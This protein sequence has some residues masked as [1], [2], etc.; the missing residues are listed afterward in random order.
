[1]PEFAHSELVPASADA[2]FRRYFRVDSGRRTR[3]AMDA[4]PP[5]EDCKPFVQIAG[6]LNEMGLQVPEVFEVDIERGFLL[7]SDLGEQRY[8]DAFSEQSEAADTLYRDA[9]TALRTLQRAGEKHLPA[10]PDFDA[11]LLRFEMSLFHDWLCERHLGLVFSSADENCWAECCDALV[12][13]AL[14][15]PTVFVH[16][17]YH[18]RNLM[19]TPENNPGI[20]DFQDAVSGPLTYDLVSLLRDCYIRWPDEK[21][22]DW[23][24]EFYAALDEDLRD[25]MDDATFLQIFDLTGVHRHLKAAGI[26]AR[27]MLRDGKVSYLNHVPRTLQYIVD[28]G[29]RC[30]EIE[31]LADFIETRC[32]PALPASQ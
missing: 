16:R 11:A 17:D 30:P 22:Q 27:L 3:I 24:L 25:A 4:P 28:A 15:Q 10:L 5:E 31:F 18:S 20:L 14:M 8:L 23:A 9:M 13:N 2:S 1:M 32:L 19:L 7:I 29:A 12:L 21:V 6:F 26:F